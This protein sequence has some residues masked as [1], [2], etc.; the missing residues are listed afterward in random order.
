MNSNAKMNIVREMIFSLAQSNEWGQ[1]ERG[2]PMICESEHRFEATKQRIMGTLSADDENDL[3]EAMQ[4]VISA[5]TYAAILFGM[6]AADALCEAIA[7]P[8]VL[9]QYNLD[10][11]IAIEEREQKEDVAKAY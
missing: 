10:C 3:F 1:I 4:G 8:A 6:W 7:R 5:Y 2:D 11:L 9:S